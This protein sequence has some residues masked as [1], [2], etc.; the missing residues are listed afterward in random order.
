MV[1]FVQAYQGD[2]KLRWEYKPFG[3]EDWELFNLPVDPSARKDLAAERPARRRMPTT[4]F[5]ARL[6]SGP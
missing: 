1:P 3:K 6:A 4:S 2:W 5:L